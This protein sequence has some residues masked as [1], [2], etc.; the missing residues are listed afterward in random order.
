M[1]VTYFNAGLIVTAAAFMG[2]AFMSDSPA[3]LWGSTQNLM[4]AA[5]ASLD[6]S[7]PPNPYNSLAA[8]L[9][10]KQAQLNAEQASFDAQAQ[11]A[12]PSA[13]G[14]WGF[15][16]LCVSVALFVLVALNFYFDIRRSRGAGG[17][18]PERGFSIRLR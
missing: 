12:A 9:E 14:N 3:A 15:W 17:A 16:S 10:A 8:Q 2:F 4:A 13:P 6:A 11:Q 18:P 1:R 7:V 5:G